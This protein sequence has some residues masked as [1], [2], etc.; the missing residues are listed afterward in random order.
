M[1]QRSASLPPSPVTKVALKKTRGKR[2]QEHRKQ[3][4]YRC[5]DGDGGNEAT[6]ACACVGVRLNA[7]DLF[8]FFNVFVDPEEVNVWRGECGRFEKTNTITLQL[9]GAAS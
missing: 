1:T 5:D 4:Q 6:R 7:C 2:Q 3:L 8:I 9:T